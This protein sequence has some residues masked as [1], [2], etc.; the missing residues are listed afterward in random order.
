M[1]IS[2]LAW[3]SRAKDA[4]RLFR[5]SISSTRGAMRSFWCCSLLRKWQKWDVKRFR[6]LDNNGKQGSFGRE[7]CLWWSRNA[8]VAWQCD[9][10]K[11]ACVDVKT[12]Q[13]WFASYLSTSSLRCKFP[14][15]SRSSSSNNRWERLHKWHISSESSAE[16]K[17][18]PLRSRLF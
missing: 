17:I 14:C 12:N 5:L 13:T 8:S 7:S 16:K 6:N 2:F 4:L 10:M 3:I 9:L 11:A 1:L 15:L 18:K